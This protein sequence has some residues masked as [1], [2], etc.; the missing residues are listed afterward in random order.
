EKSGIVL[1]EYQQILLYFAMAELPDARFGDKHFTHNN[2]RYD[3]DW[4]QAQANNS[5]FFRLQAVEHRLACELVK[6]V[7]SRVLPA[8][9]TQQ[10]VFN[11]AESPVQHAALES[12]IGQSG[13]L[14][15]KKLTYH[16]AGIAEEHLLIAAQ[17]LSGRVVADRVVE[18]LLTVPAQLHTVD[19]SKPD[20]NLEPL[21]DQ[22]LESKKI[23]TEAKL[24]DYFEKENTKLE[25]WAD[26]RRRALEME[27]KE[28]DGQIREMKKAARGL[29]NLQEKIDARRRI[30]HKETER[31]NAMVAYQQAK[32]KIEEDEDKLLDEIEDK[33]KP[34]HAIEDL[35]CVPWT[36]TANRQ[37]TPH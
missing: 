19:Q 30:K 2:T 16:Y 11:L 7:K 23:E 37:N 36:L 12:F 15:V 29:A 26:D 32:K 27:V 35:F 8:A 14:Q 22:L 21:F 6:R 4:G 9:L 28:L 33:L 34:R 3:L 20:I 10:L 17:T 18:K 31:D 24:Q 1:D 5:E 13:L 25:R